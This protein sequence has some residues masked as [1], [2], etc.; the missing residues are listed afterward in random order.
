MKHYNISIFQTW[1]IILEYVK[2]ENEYS[3]QKAGY[4]RVTF[5][6]FYSRTD[7]NSDMCNCT[8]VRKQAHVFKSATE[9]ARERYVQKNV[10]C[11]HSYTQ[12]VWLMVIAGEKASVGTHTD[13]YIKLAEKGIG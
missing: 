3:S 5:L 12:T 4:L 6:A 13:A 9:N 7:S 2:L 1:N 10:V 11:A 8:K